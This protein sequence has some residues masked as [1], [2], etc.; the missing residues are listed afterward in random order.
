MEHVIDVFFRPNHDAKEDHKNGGDGYARVLQDGF[1]V[2]FVIDFKLFRVFDNDGNSAKFVA[3]ASGGFVI[4]GNQP[5]YVTKGCVS[6]TPKFA[7]VT[8]LQAEGSQAP[9]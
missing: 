7:I 8:Y 3:F 1:D 5:M 2:A 6:V 4:G 9:L